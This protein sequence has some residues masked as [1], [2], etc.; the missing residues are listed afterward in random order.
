MHYLQFSNWDGNIACLRGNVDDWS[1]TNDAYIL[2]EIIKTHL[3]IILD[4]PAVKKRHNLC[5]SYNNF[6]HFLLCDGRY[7]QDS[8]SKFKQWS[9]CEGD[10][11]SVYYGLALS[12]NMG[13]VSQ[14]AIDIGYLRFLEPIEALKV[15][16][17][18]KETVVSSNRYSKKQAIFSWFLP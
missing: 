9:I 5:C 16:K 11:N 7:C 8:E 10:L 3:L 6:G 2:S 17:L 15:R 1:S 13:I 4:L 18:Q 14:D 12:W